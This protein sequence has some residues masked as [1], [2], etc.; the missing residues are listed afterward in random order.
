MK[1]GALIVAGG[2]GKRMKSVIA[3]QYLELKG[4]TILMHT[5]EAFQRAACIDEIVVVVG[6]ADVAA[7]NESIGAELGKSKV[8]CVTAGGSERQYSVMN[9][10]KQISDDIDIIMVHDGV[11]PFVTEDN[12]K[13]L[14]DGVKEGE[15]TL[16]AVRVKDTVK[17][18]DNNGYVVDTPR[19]DTL[20]LAQT[21]Q[22]FMRDDLFAAYEAAEN[23]G[24]L[25]TDDAMLAER[26]GVKIKIIEGE[27][28][29]IKITTPEDLDLAERIAD[30]R[31]LTD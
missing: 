4:K 21:P 7:V 20:W 16:L 17:V 28:E 8:K 24:V 14:I 3:K 13:S 6:E 2:S 25:G 22:C 15:G 23:A 18:C 9:G 27:Y 30:K 5:I 29:N 11:R 1:V 26:N 10:L 12:M 31:K 19:R